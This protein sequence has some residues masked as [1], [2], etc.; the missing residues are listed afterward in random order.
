MQYLDRLLDERRHSTGVMTD[1]ATSAPRPRTATSPRASDPRSLAC[2]ERCVQLDGLLSEHEAQAELGPRLRRA[3]GADRDRTASGP[4]TACSGRLPAG[5]SSSAARASSSSSR[6][7]FQN[8]PGRGQMAAGRGARLHQPRAA[9]ADHDDH[10]RRRDPA[11]RLVQRAAG[12]L[13]AARRRG[14]GRARQL[15]RR[16]SGSRPA[17]TRS[18]QWSPRARSSPKPRSR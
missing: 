15:G 16:S 5:S 9:R 11:V 2:Q 8:Y 17:P 13:D 7:Q 1:A 10:P 18:P 14:V 6:P 12:A 4:A 3:P